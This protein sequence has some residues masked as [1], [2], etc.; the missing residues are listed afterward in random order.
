MFFFDCLVEYRWSLSVSV[1]FDVTTGFWELSFQCRDLDFQVQ[2]FP[3]RLVYV[4][5]AASDGLFPAVFWFATPKTASVK[6]SQTC[7]SVHWRSLEMVGVIGVLFGLCTWPSLRG[8]FRFPLAIERALQGL[9]PR[10][11]AGDAECGV[12][13]DDVCIAGLGLPL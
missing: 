11:C 2:P 13:Q 10:S 5:F 9:E 7:G 12:F 1:R 8:F 3:F 6:W 4:C